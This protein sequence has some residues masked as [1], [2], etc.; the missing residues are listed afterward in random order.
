MM[1]L[2]VFSSFRFDFMSEH[3]SYPPLR[4]KEHGLVV[5]THLFPDTHRATWYDGL[6]HDYR[7]S[8]TASTLAEEI[9]FASQVIKF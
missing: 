8:C 3:F 1:A 6:D 9:M 7:H 4:R 5:S 2:F